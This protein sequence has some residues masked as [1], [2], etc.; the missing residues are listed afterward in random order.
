MTEKEGV[1]FQSFLFA[2]C[3]VGVFLT[4][5]VT[6]SSFFFLLGTNVSVAE[7][8]RTNIQIIKPHRWIARSSAI[9]IWKKGRVIIFNLL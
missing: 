5:R 8:L 1:N 2:F 3:C 7:A 6:F 4:G 9:H